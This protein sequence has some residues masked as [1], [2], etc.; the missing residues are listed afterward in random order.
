MPRRIE[1]EEDDDDRPR[2]RRRR[3]TDDDDDDDDDDRPRRR[4]PSADVDPVGF[5][6]PTDVSAWSIISCYAGL[7]GFCLPFV[8]ILFAIPGLICGIV[9]LR[10]RKK[11]ASYGAVTSDVRA[12]IG[13]VLSSL[14]L[15]GNGAFLAL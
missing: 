4:R 2:R 9:A 6:V 12:V 1:D 7:I 14:S 5:I 8:G 3:D 13:V 15:L 11:A 10:R